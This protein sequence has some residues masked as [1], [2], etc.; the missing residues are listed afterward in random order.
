MAAGTDSVADGVLYF[1]IK[2]NIMGNIIDEMKS[3][4][5]KS[6]ILIWAKC[7]IAFFTSAV[8]ESQRLHSPKSHP[9]PNHD[10]LVAA[11]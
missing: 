8:H 4:S 7:Y 6:K 2:S 10:Q 3:N 11:D 9:N 5:W 1:P